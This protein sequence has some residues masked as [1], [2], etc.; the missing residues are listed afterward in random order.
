VVKALAFVAVV[1]G[2]ALAASLSAYVE[3]R[4]DLKKICS[5]VQL[6]WLAAGEEPGP[7]SEAS[8]RC[9]EWMR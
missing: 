6:E 1:F 9:G 2:L 7:L 8:K 4:R 5:D 3:A